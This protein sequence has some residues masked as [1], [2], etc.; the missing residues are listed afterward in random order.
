MIEFVSSAA[1]PGSKSTR[2]GWGSKINQ[3]LIGEALSYEFE[4]KVLNAFGIEIDLP[5]WVFKRLRKL[6]LL[7]RDRPT[8]KTRIRGRVFGPMALWDGPDF[9]PDRRFRAFYLG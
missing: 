7:K 3:L 1:D 4:G 6:H 9:R 5:L 8:G 2:A